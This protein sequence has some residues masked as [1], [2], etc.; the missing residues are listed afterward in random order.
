[1]L[2]N[3][4]RLEKIIEGKTYHLLCDSDSPIH[5]VQEALCSFLGHCQDVIKVAQAAQEPPVQQT[6]PVEV[7][8]EEVETAPEVVQ[9]GV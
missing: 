7:D 5:H 1:M 4:V 3:I 9:D 2:K 6:E 8:A